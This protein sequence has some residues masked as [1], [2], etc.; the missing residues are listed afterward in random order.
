MAYWTKTQLLSDLSGVKTSADSHVA[1]AG[2]LHIESLFPI[3]DV[4]TYT[5]ELHT[6]T[7]TAGNETITWNSS[8]VIIEIQSGVSTV[9]QVLSASETGTSWAVLTE[10]TSGTLTSVAETAMSDL[11]EYVTGLDGYIGIGTPE[12]PGSEGEVNGVTKY[13]V[14]V[15]EVGF[16]EA[17]KKPTGYR[18]NVTF[19][20]WHEGQSDERAWFE[21]SEPKNTSD[22][23]VT[24]YGETYASYSK[25]YFSIELKYRVLG[26]LIKVAKDYVT[27]Q[28]PAQSYHWA[29]EFVKD[30]A[31]FMDAF[32][33]S[34]AA[35]SNIRAAGNAITDAE[36]YTR[37][38]S[39]MPDIATAFGIT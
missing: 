18:K 25:I 6:G 34:L 7:V 4:N 12:N 3:S 23:D 27:A 2:V 17:S 20:V 9:A 14:N 11:P 28:T 30:P 26:T 22:M 1:G 31:Y 10:G 21:K 39:A 33:C 37:C 13:I 8:S 5:V 24:A 38:D 16:S 36:L 35:N 29:Q 15:N 19:Y 32:M